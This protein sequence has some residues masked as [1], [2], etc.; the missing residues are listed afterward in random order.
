MRT[1]NVVDSV[2]MALFKVSSYQDRHSLQKIMFWSVE[3]ILLT[4]KVLITTTAD[5]TD[6]FFH[7]SEIIRLYIS[8]E[9]SAWQ[10]IH[11]VLFSLK[12]NK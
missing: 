1:A 3:S 7:F 2:E 9:S 12:N 10:T 6:F 8:C 5:D 11:F 4:L